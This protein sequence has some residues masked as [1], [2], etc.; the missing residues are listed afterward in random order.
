MGAAT[1]WQS[2]EGQDLMLRALE[3]GALCWYDPSL[4]AHD[5]GVDRRQADTAF[6]AKA[7]AYGRGMGFVL[8]K[9]HCGKM[10][11]ANLL[12]RALA[13]STLAAATGRMPLARFHAATALGRLEGVLRRCFRGGPGSGKLAR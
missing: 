2:A 3:V 12:A 11:I 8:R 1:P 10:M 9:H 6:V 13:G 5:A 4:N 7:R